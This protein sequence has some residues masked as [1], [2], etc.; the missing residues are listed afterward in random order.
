MGGAAGAVAG[1]FFLSNDEVALLN[2]E[3]LNLLPPIQTFVKGLNGAA[4]DEISGTI[5]FDSA[6]SIT[7][8]ADNT[9]TNATIFE[10]DDDI[11]FA[12]N[13]TQS[14]GIITIKAAEDNTGTLTINTDKTIHADAA[15]VDI[16]ARDIVFNG[17]INANDGG[18]NVTITAKADANITS[19]G[20]GGSL[21][22]TTRKWLYPRCYSRFKNNKYRQYFFENP[23]DITIVSNSPSVVSLDSSNDITISNNFTAKGITA[24]TVD[25]LIFKLI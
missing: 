11:T 13:F 9:I 10:A 2:T 7:D 24:V 6:E 5:T 21:G 20:G 25:D 12:N 14:N 18:S 1:T 4:T 22:I 19:A 16:L 8:T 17:G 15:A 23:G 3:T